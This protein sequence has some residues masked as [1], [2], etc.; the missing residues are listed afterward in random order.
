MT[1]ASNQ[2]VDR[3]HSQPSAVDDRANRAFALQSDIDH[4]IFFGFN[5]LGY[6]KA[7]VSQSVKLLLPFGT[8]EG[9]VI[10]AKL[11]RLDLKLAIVRE[12]YSCLQ[13]ESFLAHENLHKA[14][15]KHRNCTLSDFVSP[16]VTDNFRDK[17]IISE[18]VG[19]VG[20][21]KGA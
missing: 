8:F 14:F 1:T 18:F 10:E 12:R 9:R 6:F 13:H 3:V 16:K 20:K 2:R 11:G 7:G 17:R 4:A 15:D 5:V 19:T 21:W